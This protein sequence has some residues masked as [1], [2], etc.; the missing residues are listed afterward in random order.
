MS[1]V[2]GESGRR[3]QNRLHVHVIKTLSGRQVLCDVIRLFVSGVIE[4][5]TFVIFLAVLFIV[6]VFIICVVVNNVVFSYFIIIIILIL[7]I[8][9]LLFIIIIL[10]HITSI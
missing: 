2:D 4:G 9:I 1:G 6:T 10:F 3:L 5:S 8:I 7:L